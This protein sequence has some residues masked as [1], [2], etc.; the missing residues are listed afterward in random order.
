[1]KDAV[2]NARVEQAVTS[3][4]E[5]DKRLKAARKERDEIPAS[6]STEALHRVIAA[7]RRQG[8]LDASIQSN[9]SQLASL[10]AECVADL[11]RLT[12]WVGELEGVAGLRLPNR[13]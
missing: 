5:T 4:R 12:I 1:S 8:E 2:L 13:E 3:L 11:S 7:A 10:E 9:Q 6:D